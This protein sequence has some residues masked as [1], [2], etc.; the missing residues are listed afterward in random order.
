MSLLRRPSTRD[1]QRTH[2]WRLRR[3]FRAVSR[4]L[5]EGGTMAG[6]GPPTVSVP[7]GG[8]WRIGRGSD[9][10]AVRRPDARTLMSSE[11]GN[12]FDS[13]DASYGV[14]YF[15]TTLRG[16]FGETL[17]RF[18]PSL[19]MR[20]LVESDWEERGF[21]AVGAVP[22]EWR[23][24]RSAARVEIESDWELLDI[25]SRHTHQ[26]LRREL[27]LGLSA[28]GY[29]DLDVATIRGRDRRVTRLISAW[30]Y[31]AAND[32]GDLLYGGIRYKS[33]LDSGWECWAVF[34][35]VPLDPIETRPI[36]WETPDL[37]AM[38]ADFELA[39]F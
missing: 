36:A 8:V 16:C 5:I 34:E 3:T 31:L 9:P 37:R 21:M 20:T 11:S 4:R 6:V 15:S 28:L 30:A 1:G 33:R 39:V 17:A 25:E 13:P 32:D 23:H 7:K 14:L 24:R 18:R 35:D 12:R 10:L 2:G 22:Q 27:A 38:A 26:Y 19:P 29:Q